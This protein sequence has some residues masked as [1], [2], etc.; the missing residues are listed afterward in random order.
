MRHPHPH[1]F[2]SICPDYHLLSNLGLVVPGCPRPHILSPI[3]DQVCISLPC[4][5]GELTQYLLFNAM[6]T[7]STVVAAIVRPMCSTP[8]STAVSMNSLTLEPALRE[9]PE[10]QRLEVQL[11]ED[12][13]QRPNCAFGRAK[14]YLILLVQVREVCLH[15][16]P[17]ELID[18]R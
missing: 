15:N 3:Y 16:L 12:C 5:H 9:S 7:V 8:Y 11:P 10:Y 13:L 14:V 18:C 4:R 2:A 17:L 6:P 1:E